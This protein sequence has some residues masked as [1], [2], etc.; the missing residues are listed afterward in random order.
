MSVDN[1]R[2]VATL[3]VPVIRNSVIV[4]NVRR[5]HEKRLTTHINA[6]EGA[7]SVM[8]KMTNNSIFL[9]FFKFFEFFSSF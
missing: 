9:E 3:D 6:W 7:E 8:T 1:K 4:T 2:M 5:D